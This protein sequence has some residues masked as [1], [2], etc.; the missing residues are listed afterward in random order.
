MS[1]SIQKGAPMFD[2]FV[3]REIAQR[4]VKDQFQTQTKAGGTVAATDQKEPASVRR[5]AAALAL[6]LLPV[7]GR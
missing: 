2:L 5:T 3:L 7:S 1:E 4:R 6:R